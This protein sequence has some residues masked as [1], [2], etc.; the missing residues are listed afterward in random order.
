MRQLYLPM[1]V[2]DAPIRLFHW[3]LVVLIGFSWL[4]QEMGWMQWHL[5]SGYTMLAL[6]LFRIAWGFV[7][8]ETARFR[9]FLKSPIAGFRHLAEFHR[10]V[11]DTEI[12]HN[13]AGG[14]MVL[15]MLV[16][17]LVQVVTGLFNNDDI[18]TEGPLMHHVSKATSDYLGHIHEVNFALIEIVIVLHLVAITAYAVV[19]R[20][21]LVRPMITGKKRM[22]GAMRAPRMA[23]PLL[24]VVLLIV[25]AAAVAALVRWG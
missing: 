17:L 9:H 19:R 21:N 11:P 14:W 8:S 16:L 15:V 3:V 25:A 1:R 23:S 24:A 18:S 20:Q 7:G 2:W 10:R 5:L 22:P 4:T 13:A 6:L 12:G